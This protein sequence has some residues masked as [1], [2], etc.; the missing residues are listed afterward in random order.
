MSSY[1]NFF[2][3]DTCLKTNSLYIEDLMKFFLSHSPP[4]FSL[5]CPWFLSCPPTHN[6]PHS[7]QSLQMLFCRRSSMLR[8]TDSHPRK[9]KTW[10]GPF[11]FYTSDSSDL[12]KS[13]M[14]VRIAGVTKLTVRTGHCSIWRSSWE[15]E[16]ERRI[17][18]ASA[19]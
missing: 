15:N 5:S 18:T 1:F 17:V 14:C 11:H 7:S 19:E 2:C 13:H 3:V 9:N 16:N 10:S 4:P 12:N 6:T 8:S